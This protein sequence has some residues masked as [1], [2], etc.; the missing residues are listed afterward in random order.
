MIFVKR[1]F[2]SFKK[3]LAMATFLLPSSLRIPI[4][5]FAGF[6]IGKNT[7]ISPFTVIV[8]DEVEIGNDVYISPFVLIFNLKRVKFGNKVYISLGTFVH[9]HGVGSLELGDFSATGL[10]CLINCTCDVSVGKYTCL[11][12]RVMLV[13]HGS[14]LPKNLGFSTQYFS[15]KIGNYA[16]IM[17]DVKIVPGVNIGDYVIAHPG[18]VIM[19]D[20]PSNSVYTHERNSFRTYPMSTLYRKKVDEEYINRWRNSLFSDLA[21]VIRDYF[22]LQTECIKQEGYWAV[23]TPKEAIKIWDKDIIR[24]FSDAKVSRCDIILVIKDSDLDAMQRFR[25]TNWLDINLNLYNK[26]RHSAL[27][28][29]LIFYFALKYGILFTLYER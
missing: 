14:F 15:V 6:K 12:P 23:S 10:F 29:Y 20:I 4:L 18:T 1:N 8:A 25:N 2:R 28:D 3:L 16:W 5:K 27:F 11:G 26:A 13:T 17:M 19:T 9:S 24:D 22:G 7:T 21:S